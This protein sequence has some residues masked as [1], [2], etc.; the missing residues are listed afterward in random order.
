MTVLR[1]LVLDDEPIARQLVRTYAE[2]LP[3][4]HLVGECANA[5]EA[6]AFLLQQEVDVL[7]CDIDLPQISGLDFLKALPNRPLV[8]FTTAYEQYALM[9]F[10]LDA[11]DY[12]LKPF[13]F[14]R[15]WRAFQKAQERMAF[16]LRP[17]AQAPAVALEEAAAQPVIPA[18]QVIVIKENGQLIKVALTSIRYVEAM[19]DYV[20]IFLPER[21][22]VAYL[23]MK[24]LEET[25]PAAQF[26]RVHKSYLVRN[27]T[28]L[29]F[30]GNRLTLIG[31]V[32]I[33]VGPQYRD[34]VLRALQPYVV[35]R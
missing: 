19:R 1:C 16:Q 31:Q 5:L 24:K 29:N 28:I 13:A 6:H 4:L 26:T 18:E 9:G 25:L 2:R 3:F 12:L 20:K 22:L 11:V 17:L 27:E 23:T 35:Q 15:F 7:F 30:Q 21:R 14:D 34:A 8:I 33:P 32:Q 10:E